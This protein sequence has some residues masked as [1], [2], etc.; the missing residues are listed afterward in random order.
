MGLAR[1]TSIA[2]GFG[3]NAIHH[4]VDKRPP[5]SDTGGQDTDAQLNSGENTTRDVVPC[6][7]LAFG[8]TWSKG[9]EGDCGKGTRL[10]NTYNLDLPMSQQAARRKGGQC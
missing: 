4:F 5:G 10:L 8:G 3:G 1:G 2:S 7:C 9:I 6:R